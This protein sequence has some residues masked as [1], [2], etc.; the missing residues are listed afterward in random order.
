MNKEPSS[1][2]S[3]TRE[4]V[5]NAHAAIR[6][7]NEALANASEGP[8]LLSDDDLDQVTGAGMPRV[9]KAGFKKLTRIKKEPLY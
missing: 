4:S 9:I 6:Q 7:V 1:L 3:Q 5:Q 2:Q 8:K